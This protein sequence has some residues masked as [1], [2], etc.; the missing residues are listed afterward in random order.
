MSEHIEATGKPV[1]DLSTTEQDLLDR[2]NGLIEATNEVTN[3]I[4]QAKGGDKEQI[5]HLLNTHE[6]FAEYRNSMAQVELAKERLAAKEKE[7]V[8]SAKVSAKE[9]L[10]DVSG[11]DIPALNAER[12]TNR[13]TI[14]SLREVIKAF[15]PEEKFDAYQEHY[16]VGELVGNGRN[17]GPTGT[18]AKRYHFELIQV[19]EETFANLTELGSKFGLPKEVV[20]QAVVTAAGTEDVKSRAGEELRFPITHESTTINVVAVPK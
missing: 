1:F 16:G 11:V 8:E 18:G 14:N 6:A 19:G 5:S 17:N 13:K 2:Y 3:K 4:R 9:L 12:A 15:I 7:L 10:P 20:R